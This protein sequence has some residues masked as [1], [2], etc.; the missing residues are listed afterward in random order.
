MLRRL[1]FVTVL[2]GCGDPPASDLDGDGLA[3]DEDECVSGFADEGIDADGD[4]KDATQDLC[5]HDFNAAA[6]DLDFDGIPDACD[7]FPAVTGGDTRRCVT[8]FRVGWLNASHL[9]ARDGETPWTLAPAPREADDPPPPALSASAPQ[10]ASIVSAFPLEH[11]SVSF[12][13]VGTAR[14]A[15][16]TATFKL[17]LRAN[18]DAPS[19]QDLA[20][21][22]DG[23]QNLFVWSGNMQRAVVTLPVKIDGWFRLRATVQNITDHTVFCRVTAADG[24]SISTRIGAGPIAGGRYGFAA[25][26][27]DATIDSLVIDSNEVAQPF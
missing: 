11:A 18:P 17:W 26:G 27:I 21:G 20:C 9:D 24:T 3:D 8:G 15:S 5:P 13:V 10:D 25:S 12:D 19:E 4:A 1:V 16:P 2:V 22:I 23:A 7:P 6:G 14:F